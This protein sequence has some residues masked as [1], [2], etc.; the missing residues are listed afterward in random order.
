MNARLFLAAWVVGLPGVIAVAFLAVPVFVAGR[1]LPVPL[2]AAQLASVAQGAVL[3]A[4]AVL[5]GVAL[6]PRVGLTAPVLSAFAAAQSLSLAL[7][8]QLVPGMLGGLAGAAMLRLFAHYAPPELAQLQA[9]APMPA[10][11]RL[12]YGG[13]T[14]ELLIRWGLMTLLVWLY[15]RT[16]QGGVGAPSSTAMWMGIG[17]S[18]LVFGAGHLPAA[19]AFLGQVPLQLAVHIILA[20][21]AFGVVAGWLYWRYGLESAMLAHTSAHATLLLASS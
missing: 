16:V 11:V 17:I 19:A 2:W 20:N 8:P 15:W 3:L 10:A 5:A 13:I 9:D 12:L 18:A 14:E 1:P 21:A 6:A 4:V 7:R